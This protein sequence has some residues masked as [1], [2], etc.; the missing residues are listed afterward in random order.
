MT[1][2]IP[3]HEGTLTFPAVLAAKLGLTGDGEVIVEDTPLGIL[4]K[5]KEE[6]RMY[7]DEEMETFADEGDLEPHRAFLE[8]ITSEMAPGWPKKQ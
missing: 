6:G 4:L 2:T 3:Y 7:T 8:S 1:A 5:P